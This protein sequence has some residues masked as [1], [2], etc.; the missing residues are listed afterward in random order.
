MYVGNF[1]PFRVLSFAIGQLSVKTAIIRPLENF[2]LYSI[3]V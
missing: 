3:K 1:F 2:L